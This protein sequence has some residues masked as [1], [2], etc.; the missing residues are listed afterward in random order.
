[1]S[2]FN[3]LEIH[4][5]SMENLGFWEETYKKSAI[6]MLENGYKTEVIREWEISDLVTNGDKILIKWTKRYR[7]LTDEQLKEKYGR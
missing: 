1:M 7:P 4:K 6:Q 2:E 3:F 5:N